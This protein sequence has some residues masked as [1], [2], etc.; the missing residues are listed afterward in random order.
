MIGD[1]PLLAGL[2]H[3]SLDSPYCCVSVIGIPKSL[4]SCRPV[5]AH[6]PPQLLLCGL[7]SHELVHANGV[8][9][10]PELLSILSCIEHLHHSKYGTHGWTRTMCPLIMISYQIIVASLYPSCH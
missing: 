6:M 4:P 2:Y 7:S 8:G 3:L 1:V 9:L 5:L 10:L